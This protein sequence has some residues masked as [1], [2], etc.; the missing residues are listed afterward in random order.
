MA[1]SLLE[2]GN[3]KLDSVITDIVGKSERAMLSRPIR[4]SERLQVRL[5]TKARRGVFLD[6]QRRVVHFHNLSKGQK[7]IFGR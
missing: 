6:S 3:V 7:G 2:S 4:S 5:S 1:W